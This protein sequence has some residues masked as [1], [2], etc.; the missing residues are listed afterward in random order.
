MTTPAFPPGAIG[1]IQKQM[2]ARH[3]QTLKKRMPNMITIQSD[4]RSTESD[5]DASEL[6]DAK[7]LYMLIR[8]RN[9]NND[10]PKFVAPCQ[11]SR[12]SVPYVE[13][14]PAPADDYNDIWD[15]IIP[16]GVPGTVVVSQVA[17][18]FPDT[19]EL[20]RVYTINAIAQDRLK[21]VA[22]LTMVQYGLRKGS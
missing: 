8:D 19:E 13:G 6:N 15:V 22:R 4:P 14:G 11:V 20:E 3:V 17:L 21:Y 18:I 5:L 12:R 10:F 9:T 1:S 7:A 16:G 2:Q